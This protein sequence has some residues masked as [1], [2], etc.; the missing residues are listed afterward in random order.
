MAPNIR[1]ILV[2]YDFSECSKAALEYA[3]FLAD[4]FGATVEIVHIIE[5]IPLRIANSVIV[6]DRPETVSEHAWRVAREE[7]AR[8]AETLGNREVSVTWDL[9]SR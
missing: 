4:T 1:R 5:P 3:G 2:P 8:A 7:T 6:S 9:R